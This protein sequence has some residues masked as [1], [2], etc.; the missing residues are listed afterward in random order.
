MWDTCSHR[1]LSLSRSLRA[2]SFPLLV[3]LSRPHSSSHVP[4]LCFLRLWTTHTRL[5]VCL[6]FVTLSRS[7]TRSVPEPIPCVCT[8][9]LMLIQLNAGKHPTR[10]AA[11]F[12]K[13][14]PI[15][16]RRRWSRTGLV[17]N[18]RGPPPS[19]SPQLPAPVFSVVRSA[20]RVAHQLAEGLRNDC[21]WNT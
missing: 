13:L 15:T 3:T 9:A 2:R 12:Q 19:L 5:L 6:S 17:E 7:R 16:P 4:A 18:N 10:V 20:T 1:T 14:R 21:R 8:H 11:R